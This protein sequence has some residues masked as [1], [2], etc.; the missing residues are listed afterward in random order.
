MIAPLTGG[1]CGNGSKRQPSAVLC[2]A[3]AVSSKTKTIV[4]VGSAFDVMEGSTLSQEDENAAL[5][6]SGALDSAISMLREIKVFATAHTCI[7]ERINSAQ[8]F[9][10]QMP[11]R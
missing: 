3:F 4:E 11:V 2:L 5:V 10:L 6:R 7:R 9:F 8:C 1:L